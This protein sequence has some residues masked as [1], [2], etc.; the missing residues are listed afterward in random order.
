MCGHLHYKP[1]LRLLG[2]AASFR[3]PKSLKICSYLLPRDHFGK[4]DWSI[5][6]VQF[7]CTFSPLCAIR[8][9]HVKSPLKNKK[10]HTTFHCLHTS[11]TKKNKNNNNNISCMIQLLYHDFL[12]IYFYSVILYG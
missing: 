1:V 6:M 9:V 2:A 11:C 8:T 7:Y 5:F 4:N 12:M 3:A 10:I